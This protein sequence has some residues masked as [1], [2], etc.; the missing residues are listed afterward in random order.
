MQGTEQSA[1]VSWGTWFKSTF[2]LE[3][4]KEKFNVSELN[5]TRIGELAV[6]FGLAFLAGLLF[7]KYAKY[8]IL[9]IVCNVIVIYFL[10]AWHIITIDWDAVS[11]FF[12]L[13]PT[14]NV[15]AIAAPYVQKA[16]HNLMYVISAVF[17]FILGF[18]VG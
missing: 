6:I 16:R 14:T 13:T 7:R 11:R 9:A 15:Q 10:D 2:S 3:A 12:A 17:G 8:L 4:L 18:K 1:V 5:S